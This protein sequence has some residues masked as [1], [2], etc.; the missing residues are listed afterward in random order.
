MN[1]LLKGL[2]KSLSDSDVEV[3]DMGV[4]YLVRQIPQTNEGQ[5]SRMDLAKIWRGLFF[6]MWHS[7]GPF[8][9]D[10]LAEKIGS[11]VCLW[12]SPASR[13]EFVRAFFAEMR[14]MW[15]KIDD[16][17]ADKFRRLVRCI[18]AYTC[19]ALALA[20]YSDDVV[21]AFRSILLDH[22]YDVTMPEFPTGLT[23]FFSEIF[24]ET[25]EEAATTVSGPASDKKK[26]T[27]G[28][29]KA[30]K[31]AFEEG[32]A[33][34]AEAVMGDAD[35]IAA[36]EAIERAGDS[37]QK[38][39]LQIERTRRSVFVQSKKPGQVKANV[40]DALLDAAM[41]YYLKG[42]NR[43]LV[44]TITETIV[45]ALAD[46]ERFPK[47][48]RNMDG[49]LERID[50]VLADE[51]VFVSPGGRRLA[52][53]HSHILEF[54]K[55]GWRKQ[56]PRPLDEERIKEAVNKAFN[57]ETVSAMHLRKNRARAAALRA[58]RASGGKKR[59]GKLSFSKRQ[60]LRAKKQLHL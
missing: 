35:E 29:K 8:V 49:F 9:Q 1:T 51:K 42:T 32:V 12:P 24:L 48:Q 5:L 14:Q 50:K 6:C 18:I 26:K 60:K 44:N 28:S 10:A 20:N 52:H 39:Q 22:V 40:A 17:R 31:I 2:A 53:Y 33:E 38:L 45:D 16:L 47:I 4:A 3:R 58:R 7:D 30:P 43:T 34:G 25:L 46:S 54:Q 56:E 59:L 23:V 55:R 13:M 21:E 27:K 41:R 11:M 15:N 36:E 57:P 37:M 19:R